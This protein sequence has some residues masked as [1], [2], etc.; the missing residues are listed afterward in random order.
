MFNSQNPTRLFF[1]GRWANLYS[2]LSHTDILLFP[3]PCQ[4]LAVV[5]IRIFCQCIGSKKLFHYGLISPLITREVG[6]FHM[7]IGPSNFLFHNKTVCILLL[8]FYTGCYDFFLLACRSSLCILYHFNFFIDGK[9]LTPVVIC[10]LS[11]WFL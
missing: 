11:L 2:N 3:S 9:Y 5:V 10:L 7:I 8:C 6:K 1:I 4:H